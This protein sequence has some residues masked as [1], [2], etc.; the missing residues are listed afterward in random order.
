MNGTRLCSDKMMVAKVVVA[1]AI[2]ANKLLEARVLV[3]A[4]D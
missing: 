4:S 3:A 2:T 1:D